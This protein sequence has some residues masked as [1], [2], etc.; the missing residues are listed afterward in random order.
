M[1]VL[2]GGRAPVCTAF[3]VYPHHHLAAQQA[4]GGMGDAQDARVAGDGRQEGEGGERTRCTGTGAV[5]GARY[6][7]AM[8]DGDNE[9]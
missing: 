7:G 3:R 5:P 8:G 9:R 6:V 2:A 4:Q 1:C